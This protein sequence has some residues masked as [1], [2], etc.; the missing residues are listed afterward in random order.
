MQIKFFL[1][2]TKKGDENMTIII[3]NIVDQER[4]FRF[5]LE[6]SIFQGQLQFT[7]HDYIPGIKDAYGDGEAVSISLFN[8]EN[9]S[10]LMQAFQVNDEQALLEAIKK[11]FDHQ[12]KWLEFQNFLQQQKITYHE[13]RINLFLSSGHYL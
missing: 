13:E 2:Q 7:F 11:F 5:V 9:T 3:Y 8:S 12:N 6:A 4:E 1:C 10:K